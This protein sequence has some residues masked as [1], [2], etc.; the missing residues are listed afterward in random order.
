MTERLGRRARWTATLVVAPGA[1]A[2]FGATVSWAAQ[3]VPSPS[4]PPKATPSAAPAPDPRIAALLQADAAERKRAA[5][6]RQQLNRLNRQL[7][8][9]HSA[10]AA[11]AKANVPAAGGSGPAGGAGG[12]VIYTP[13]ATGGGYQAPAPPPPPVA[14]PAPPPP[15]QA[16]TGASGGAR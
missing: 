15:V 5:Q 12:G 13:P 9:I 10:A 11:A 1:A 16:Q 14:A 2:L 7:A 4:S 6:L 8:K 3:T